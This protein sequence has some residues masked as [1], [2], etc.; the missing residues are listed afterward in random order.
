[1]RGTVFVSRREPRQ[2]RDR[3][4]G[5]ALADL[6][7]RLLATSGTAGVLERAGIPVDRVA[8]VSGGRATSAS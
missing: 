8:K 6:G 4:P 3:V 2:A 5:E 1:M 7:F